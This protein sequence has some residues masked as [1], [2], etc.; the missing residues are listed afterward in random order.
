MRYFNKSTHIIAT[1]TLIFS[2]LAFAEPLPRTPEEAKRIEA[3]T[4]P[5]TDFS[6]PEKYENMSGG[7]ATNTKVFGV[8]VFSQPSANMGFEQEL[9]FKVGDGFF[10]KLWVSAPSSTTSSDGLGPL[11]NARACQNCHFKDGRGR[12]ITDGEADISIF[13]RLAQKSGTK[14]THE[15][16]VPDPIY[17]HQLQDR[18]LPN[19]PAEGHMKIT[20][21]P[22]EVTLADGLVVELRKPNYTIENL[23]YGPIDAKTGVSPRIAP[24]MIGLGLVQAIPE[25]DILAWVDENDAD[26]N[27][28]SGRANRVWSAGLQDFSIGRFGHKAGNA[29]LKDQAASAFLGD[30]GLSTTLFSNSDGECTQGQTAC[31]GLPNGE[32]A[33]GV[34]V[35]DE[36]LELIDFYAR[37]LAVPERK[38]IAETEVLKGKEVFYNI[39]CT[40]CHRPKFVTARDSENSPQSFQLIWPYSDFLLHDMGE[41]LAD[42]IGE[43][44][45]QAGEWRTAPLWGARFSGVMSGEKNYLHDGRA[46]NLLE[47]VLWHGG[48]AQA[49]RDAVVALDKEQRD[50]LIAFLD[51]L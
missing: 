16:N 13:L 37:N 47:A 46:R 9:D 12:T 30:M 44:E 50:A 24:Q 51:S 32:G 43:Y 27:G 26:G 34:E 23:G 33:D 38:N 48:E 8:D 49:S 3:V 20:Y 40:N 7:A 41:G 14:G 42:E 18:S 31:Q 2:G 19:I 25:A 22:I 39:G 6:Q 4:V 35:S 36:I 45:A 29:T 1:C 10:K 21:E 17:G 11:F 28:I 15:A 5:T